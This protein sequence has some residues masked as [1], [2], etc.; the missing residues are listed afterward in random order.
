MTIMRYVSPSQH[1]H[2]KSSQSQLVDEISLQNVSDIFSLPP[3]FLCSR[4]LPTSSTSSLTSAL[5][6][7]GRISKPIFIVSIDIYK[8][9]RCLARYS[10]RATTTTQPTNW[11]PNEPASPGKNA[12]LGRSWAK[13][14]NFYWRKLKFCYPH[15]GKPT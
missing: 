15:N 10:P 6:K 1:N 2:H 14:P 4:S 5:Y 11:A 8:V 12:K 9:N 7:A 13:N 3:L